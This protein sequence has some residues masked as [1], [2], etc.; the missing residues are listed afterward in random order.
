MCRTQELQALDL[1]RACSASSNAHAG[2]YRATSKPQRAP[3]A[4]GTQLHLPESGGGGEGGGDDGGG[5]GGG[6]TSRLPFSPS[7]FCH[8]SRTLA[9]SSALARRGDAGSVQQPKSCPIQRANSPTNPVTIQ[10]ITQTPKRV[11]NDNASP[12]KS[13]CGGKGGIAGSCSSSSSKG[14]G[15]RGSGGGGG[16]GGRGSGGG[17]PGNGAR[18]GGR[19][20][21]GGGSGDGSG[22]GSGGG[23]GRR[24]SGGGGGGDGGGG[25]GSGEGGG[26]G[27]L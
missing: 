1:V 2:S 4:S 11:T 7:S 18:G 22:G 23:G 8:P 9:V 12:P 26:G 16:G 27:V 20:G 14:S 3:G 13:I 6:V 24:G 21:G 5:D 10:R 17:G 19:G 15:G 25:G